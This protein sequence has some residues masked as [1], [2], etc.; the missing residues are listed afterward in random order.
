MSELKVFNNSEFGRLEVLIIDGKEYFPATDCAEI[1]G[2]KK[3]HDAIDRHCR[4]TGTTFHGVGVVTGKKKDGSDAIQKVIKKFIDEGNL[5]RLIVSSKLP[6]AEKFESWVFDHVLPTI[7]KHGAYMTPET[8]EQALLNPDTIIQLATNLKEEQEKRKELENENKELKPKA[9]YHD[10]VLQSDSLLSV[11]QIAK[12]FGMGAPTL[13]KILHELG[14]QYKKGRR[15]YL[16]HRYQDKGY[17]QSKTYAINAE[18]TKD[19][20]YWTQKGRL[21]IYEILKEKK[22]I[23]PNIEKGDNINE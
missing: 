10:L 3:P 21:F 5:Y 23:L 13:N 16:Y 14:I 11:T 22:G 19:H 15:W 4:I 12:D 7:R 9:T 17:T 18:E 2:Y 20:M 8:I 1:L 6:E